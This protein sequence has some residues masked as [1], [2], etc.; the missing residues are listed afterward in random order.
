MSELYKR[1]RA[2]KLYKELNPYRACS[3]AE[4]FDGQE[5]PQRNYQ[6]AWQYIYDLEMYKYLQGWYGRTVSSLLEQGLLQK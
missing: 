1:P 5:I 4:N 6:V 2:T 3:I